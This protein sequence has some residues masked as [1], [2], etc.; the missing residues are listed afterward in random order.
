MGRRTEEKGL[1]RASHVTRHPHGTKWGRVFEAESRLGQKVRWWRQRKT[2]TR[3]S[4]LGLSQQPE[5]KD[6]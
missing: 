5:C 1:E 2:E 6:E 4:L 3:L